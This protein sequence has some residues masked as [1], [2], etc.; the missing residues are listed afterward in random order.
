[1]GWEA[2][3]DQID[4]KALDV[5]VTALR[6]PKKTEILEARGL[7]TVVELVDGMKSGMLWQ[8]P[9]IGLGTIR[10]IE[11]RLSLLPAAIDPD[12]GMVNWQ[13]YAQACGF[14]LVPERPVSS[15]Q[16]FLSAFPSAIEGI[17]RLHE[18]PVDRLILIERLAKEPGERKTL[19]EIARSSPQRITRERVRQRQERLLTALSNA[20]LHDDHRELGFHF[21]ESFSSRWKA[22]AELFSGK[23]EVAFREFLEGL[24][25][26]WEV[27]SSELLPNLPFVTSVLTSRAQI[28]H[29]LR[30][31]MKLHPRLHGPVSNQVARAPITWLTTGRALGDIRDRGVDTIGDFIDAARNGSLPATHTSVGK[32]CTELLA[33]LGEALD[34]DGSLDWMTYGAAMKLS[35]LPTA[36]RD[37]PEAFL[38]HL[39]VDLEEIIR[40]NAITLRAADIFRLRTCLPQSTRRT[41]AEVAEMLG[42]HGP[43]IKRE[44]SIVLDTLNGQFVD[45]DFTFSR[46][47]YRPQYL[48]WWREARLAYDEDRS[49]YLSFCNALAR[50]WSLPLGV[51]HDNAE[52]LWA[53]FARYP[54]GRRMPVR[55]RNHTPAVSEFDG[56]T[57]VLRGFRRLH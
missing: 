49:S 18:N 12:T 28:P 2:A 4:P 7:T 54:N 9:G 39:N 14:E 22:A 5:P 43:S 16:E 6:L 35:V 47:I 32:C 48:R 26:A 30:Q 1:M 56:G 38:R 31:G 24:E 11:R 55:R 45:R 42:C 46:V 52:A 44:E 25:Q 19:E 13:S 21:R 15:G 10:M 23:S 57:I 8:L 53:V 20:L 50:G 40:D 37:T 34:E 29:Q 33:A 27:P 36:G 17:L 41:L 3:I 51:V